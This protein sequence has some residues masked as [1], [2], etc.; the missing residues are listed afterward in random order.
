MSG[1]R[2]RLAAW[3]MAICLAAALN[4]ADADAA[5][6]ADAF[7]IVVDVGHTP[8][9]PGA[10]SA[11][12]T[13]EFQFNLALANRTV[14]ELDARGFA[15][16]MLVTAGEGRGQLDRRVKDANRL[17]PDLFLSIH[18]DSVQEQY[19]RTWQADGRKLR[20]SDRFSGHSIFVSR[21]NAKFRQARHFAAL[22]ADR[23]IAA[24]LRHSTHHAEPIKGENRPWI[25][26]RRGIHAF[27]GLRVLRDV[28]ATAVL[29]EAG[30]IVNRDD[31][32]AL[33]SPERQGLI[34][35]AI[36]DAARDLCE[37]TKRDV[38]AVR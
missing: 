17:S 26:E 7:R 24:G 32:I 12:G 28:K 34:A 8:Q 30:I 13:P 3:A 2:G 37:S 35:G 20:F 6:R 16:H 27:D 21:R 23:L 31:E 11:R 29:L 1:L 25:D 10:T 38:F 19:L 9:S 15:V 18:H 36:A 33:A 5:C 22:L 14:R 4:P